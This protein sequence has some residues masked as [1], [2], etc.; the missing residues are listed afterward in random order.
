MSEGRSERAKHTYRIELPSILVA[1]SQYYKCEAIDG[2]RLHSL[3]IMYPGPAVP[4][5]T[6]RQLTWREVMAGYLLMLGVFMIIVAISYP[7][8]TLAVIA[9]GTGI[10]ALY[11]LVRTATHKNQLYIPRTHICLQFAR[12]SK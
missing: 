8:I 2:E 11:R 9:T 1:N 12:R 4:P 7:N 10:Y 5:E 3:V 6:D